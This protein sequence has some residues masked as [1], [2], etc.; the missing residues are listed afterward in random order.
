MALAR[1]AT[2]NAGISLELVYFDNDLLEVV[3]SGSN[4][5]FA[6][7]ASVYLALE[8]LTDLVAGLSGF[9]E[10]ADDRRTFELGTFDQH[11]AGGGVRLTFYCLDR[12]GHAVVTAEFR[13]D[14]RGRDVET[15]RFGV[16]VEAAA[17]DRFIAAVRQIDRD[18]SGTAVLSCNGAGNNGVQLTRPGRAPMPRPRSRALD[19]VVD[20]D[21]EGPRSRQPNPR[22]PGL[23][24]EPGFR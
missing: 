14:G 13:S 16:P 23:A 11:C 17:I 2:V 12:A 9:P 4:G 6:G 1:H 18:R 3:V 8:G 21:V 10:N 5:H 20:C 15:A 22:R 24:A 7:R 19:L